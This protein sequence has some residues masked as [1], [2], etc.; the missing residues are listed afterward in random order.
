MDA[1]AIGFYSRGCLA[2]AQAMPVNGATWK[3]MR[4]SRDR[5]WGHPNLI[6]FLEKLAN[7]APETAGWPG[8]LV[9]DM[10]QPRGGPMLTGHASHQIG[11]DAD[12]WL[13]PMPDRRLTRAESEQMMA[14]GVVRP[15]GLD[16]DP[17]V[18]TSGHLGIIRA[19]ALDPQVERIF[20][21]AAIKKALCREATGDRSWLHKI[22][23]YWGHKYHF[24]VRIACP[25]GD[26]ACREQIAVP[27]GEGCDAAS[28]AFWFRPS[29]RQSRIGHRAKPR[30]GLTMASLP[31][32]CRKVLSAE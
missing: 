2:G 26:Q 30:R 14:V 4:I 5:Y 22:R 11:L 18:W 29:V 21:N 15:D 13:M 12:I 31:S 3:V 25:Q 10:S 8:I 32:E 27:P 1:H 23:P 17:K 9:G 19:A 7:E 24:H 28:L 16:V 20:V 6:R